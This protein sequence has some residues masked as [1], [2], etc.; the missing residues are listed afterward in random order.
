LPLLGS[1]KG[2]G[3]IKDSKTNNRPDRAPIQG[4]QE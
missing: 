1:P 4:G 3:S 2:S